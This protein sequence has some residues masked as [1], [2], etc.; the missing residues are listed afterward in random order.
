MTRDSHEKGPVAGVTFEMAVTLP[1]KPPTKNSRL[2]HMVRAAQVAQIRARV[3]LMATSFRNQLPKRL[4]T[5]SLAAGKRH[6][7]IVLVRPVR[8][9][10][11]LDDDNLVAACAPIRDALGPPVV[12]HTKRGVQLLPGSFWLLGDAPEQATFT[13]DQRRGTDDQYHATITITEA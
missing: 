7:H 1:C 5:K 12:R 11:H 9:V 3:A 8:S 10:R 2:H 6:A 4:Q 13:Y